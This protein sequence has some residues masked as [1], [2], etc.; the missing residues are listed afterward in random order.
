MN[1]AA[2]ELWL[3]VLFGFGFFELVFIKVVT[4]RD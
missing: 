3:R 4:L 1:Y 2:V